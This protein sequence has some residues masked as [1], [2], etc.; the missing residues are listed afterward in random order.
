MKN[1]VGKPGKKAAALQ[2]EARESYLAHQAGLADG[3]F[4]A[5]IQTH[6]IAA[7][8][9]ANRRWGKEPQPQGDD[10]QSNDCE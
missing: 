6:R 9:Q 10:P 8:R 2:A 5:Q 1:R 7:Q 4:D 3:T